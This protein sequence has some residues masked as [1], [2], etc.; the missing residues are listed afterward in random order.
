MGCHGAQLMAGVCTCKLRTY[1]S[2][3]AQHFYRENSGYFY[4]PS[5]TVCCV[6]ARNV[7]GLLEQVF[8]DNGNILCGCGECLDTSCKGRNVKQEGNLKTGSA[9][10]GVCLVTSVLT[11]CEMVLCL[12]CYWW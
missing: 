1:S 8:V 4:V 2:S 7:P 11:V 5:T 3:M 10:G 9:I 12:V 6:H